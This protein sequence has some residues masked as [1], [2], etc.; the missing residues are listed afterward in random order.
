MPATGVVVVAPE[1][2]SQSR[3]HGLQCR[4]ALD[5]LRPRRLP[6][7]GMPEPSNLNCSVTAVSGLSPRTCRR[8]V[9]WALHVHI[10]DIGQDPL[11]SK[12]RTR[13]LSST[14]VDGRTSTLA[15]H[16]AIRGVATSSCSVLAA[17]LVHPLCQ[18]RCTISAL[19]HDMPN[20]N[21]SP[22]TAGCPQ[23]ERA[24]PG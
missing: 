8:D 14:A 4:R 13:V 5:L 22:L 9:R 23:T 15:P 16:Q 18:S 7:P 2:Q 17:V 1:S 12:S 10:R 21:W 24:N 19:S 20:C 6:L 3:G 11:R